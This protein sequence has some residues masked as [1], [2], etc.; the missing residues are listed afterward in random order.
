MMKTKFTLILFFVY[1]QLFSQDKVSES[2][3]PPLFELVQLGKTINSPYHE[4][5]P[6][7]SPNGK[8]LYFFVANHPE[9]NLGKAGSQDIW[10]AERDSTGEWQQAR[11]MPAPLNNRRYNQVFTVLN[12]GNTLLVRGGS[13]KASEGFS[14]TQKTGSGWSKPEALKIAAYD[15]MRKGVYSGGCMSSDGK[16]LLI[17]FSEVA[18]SK[19]SDIYVS[20][21]Q[22]NG[23]F[24][25]PKL[26]ASNINTRGDEFGPFLAA[27]DKTLFFASSRPGGMGGMDLYKTERLD[28]TWMKW[29]DPVNMGAPVNT[30]GFDAYYSVDASGMDAFTTRAYMSRDG[31]S[32]DVLGLR[33]V[34]P[35]P[36]VISLDGYVYDK[37]TNEP[38]FVSIEYAINGKDSGWIETDKTS[39]YYSLELPSEGEYTFKINTEGYFSTQ[40]SLAVELKDE[41]QFISKNIYLKPLEVGT[42]V[43]LNNIFFDF[44]KATLRPESFPELD[45][46]I[47]LLKKNKDLEIE[48]GGHT[49]NMGS[50][51]YN[52][53]L[54]NERAKSVRQYIVK[55]WISENRVSYKGYGKD[56]PEVSNETEEGRQ[57]NRRVEFVILKN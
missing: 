46:V 19:F 27:D 24:S 30:P 49:D 18:K 11:H 37:K 3:I 55:E 28:E 48:I 29:S 10:Y 15:Q 8:I 17:Y 16:V 39:G 54:S 52:E 35:E 56:K 36:K 45:L 44:D 53:K 20:F 41:N 51:E 42:A 40:D 7:V 13:G 5:A 32:L 50:A 33:P 4:S 25:K 21:R 1:V 47:D 38:L 34:K 2:A 31:G 26:L 43:R 14:L 23:D 6:I 9:N 22:D 12:N 57:T